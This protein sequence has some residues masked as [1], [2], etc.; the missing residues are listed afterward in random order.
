MAK[1]G[2][3]RVFNAVVL[4][5]GV[6]L[7]VW[8]LLAMDTAEIGALLARAGWSLAIAFPLYV[9][10]LACSTAAWRACLR[11]PV[12]FLPLL[13]A[14][15]GGHAINGLG[16]TAMGEV[17]KGTLLARHAEG[18]EIVASLVLYGYLNAIVAVAF[19][20][21]GPAVC[22]L[23][24]DVP[25]DVVAAIFGAA[26]GFGLLVGA[27]G[28]AL[29]RGLLGKL[30]GV[31]ARLRIVKPE[32][33]ERM[34]E[35]AAMV[36]ERVRGFR[37]ERPGA[38]LRALALSSAARLLQ[39]LEVCVLLAALMPE[40]DLAFVALLGLFAHSA[41]QL[42]SWALAFVPGRVGVAEGG[43]ALVFELLALRPEL[44]LSLAILRRVRRTAG[45][46]IGLVIALVVESRSRRAERAQ[47]S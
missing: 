9:L 6:A 44:G 41:A 18:E 10:N 27:F 25:S 46:A 43:T 20:V 3:K 15:W 24:L 29:R 34:R 31:G 8:L 32:R 40:R 39:V 37:R 38:Y 45:I 47:T 4:S 22:L 30:V 16:I 28:V 33:V 12:P 21:L 7:F 14:F 35:R 13:G 11:P 42:L 5:L 1:R 19:S 26:A 2:T 17:V 23:W 36:D